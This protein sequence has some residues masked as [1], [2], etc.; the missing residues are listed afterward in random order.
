MEDIP[1]IIEKFPKDG[2]IRK[3]K[4]VSN[5]FYFSLIFN[6]NKERGNMFEISRKAIF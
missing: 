2:V 6:G 1:D 3:K 5:P 4:K